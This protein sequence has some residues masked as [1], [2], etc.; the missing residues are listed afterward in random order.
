MILLLA[1]C[2]LDIVAALCK[3]FALLVPKQLAAA[4][5]STA[6]YRTINSN[7]FAFQRWLQCGKAH[8]VVAQR[9]SQVTS[10]CF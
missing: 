1:L 5:I 6:D 9:Q 10:L 4:M 3:C 8:L 7:A 2:L